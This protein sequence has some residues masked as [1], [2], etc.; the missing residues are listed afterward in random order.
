MSVQCMLWLQCVLLSASVWAFGAHRLE[1]AI[2]LVLCVGV[3]VSIHHSVVSGNQ[4]FYCVC[5]LAVLLLNASVRC[6]GLCRGG[7]LCGWL[8]GN[9]LGCVG[10]VRSVG[11]LGLT[12][13]DC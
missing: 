1:V 7:V 6:R 2:S 13:A 8:A 9:W 3:G 4:L 10:S 12:A 11:P 5:S